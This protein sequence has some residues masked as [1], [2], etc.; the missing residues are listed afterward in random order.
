M[1]SGGKQSP[2]HTTQRNGCRH[3]ELDTRVGTVDVA[4]PKLRQ[5]TY[6]LEWLLARLKRAE[7]AMITVVADCYLAGEPV[8]LFV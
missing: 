4:V 8:R 5:G 2:N 3:R 7:T 6:F 1:P